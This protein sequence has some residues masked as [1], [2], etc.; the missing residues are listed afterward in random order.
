VKCTV[1]GRDGWASYGDNSN[2]SGGGKGTLQ[3]TLA[4]TVKS[5]PGPRRHHTAK[6]EEEEEEKGKELVVLPELGCLAT[7]IGYVSRVSTCLC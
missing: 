2:W 5:R 7:Y 1:K 3:C 6:R 4:C